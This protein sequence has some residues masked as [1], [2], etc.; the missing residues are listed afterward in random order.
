MSCGGGESS[1]AAA[2]A[3]NDGPPTPSKEELVAMKK[4]RL[5][6][7]W[8]ELLAEYE[9]ALKGQGNFFIAAPK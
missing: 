5:E 8:Q 9:V 1:N 4:E 2:A 7:L 3:A 6:E